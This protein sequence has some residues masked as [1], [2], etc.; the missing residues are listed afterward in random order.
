[1]R[2][3]HLPVYYDNPYQQQLM[4][5][6]TNLGHTTIDGGGGGIFLRTALHDWRA[7]I[8]H[9]HWLHPYLIRDSLA[10]TVCR[11]LRFLAEVAALKSHG[12]TIAWTIHN[13]VNHNNTHPHC[14]QAFSTA[15]AKFTDACFVHSSATA[16]ATAARF[17]I[18]RNKLHVIPHPN[19]IGNY[20]NT[21]TKPEARSNIDRPSEARVF[22][23]LGLIEPYKGVEDLVEAF[24]L[25]SSDAHLVV[26]GKIAAPNSSTHSNHAPPRAPA[27]TSSPNASPTSISK[28]SSTP[29]ITSSSRLRR[30][31]PA[32][33]SPSPCRFPN[34]SSPRDSRAWKKYS[35][36][37]ASP[38]SPPDATAR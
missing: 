35:L 33:R 5:A 25:F 11:S 20:P 26:A 22:L 30:S 3:V 27:F 36:L 28:T 37:P 16:D 13:L 19:Y 4:D 31:S 12:S 6:Q 23:F 32:A 38:G 29:P 18:P 9:F 21:I 1:M 14:E 17:S 34:P 10:G 7:D 15:F 8:I 24:S 2:I